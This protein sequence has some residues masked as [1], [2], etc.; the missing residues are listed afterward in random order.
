MSRATAGA[1]LVL[2][3]VVMA[4]S[5]GARGPVWIRQ[6]AGKN[7]VA[8]IGVGG[9]SSISITCVTGRDPVYFL[10]VRGPATGLKAGRGVKAVI[11][12]RR[13]VRFRFDRAVLEAGGRIR[14]SSHGGYRGSVGDQSGTLEAIESIATA[15]GPIRVSSGA[16]RLSAPSTGVQSAMAPVIRACGDLKRMIKRAEG[17]EGEIN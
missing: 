11:E 13:K 1:G 4:G 7:P 15:R 6:S 12:G 10:D 2:A 17:R 16:F 9:G 14:L 8:A 3:L 5:A